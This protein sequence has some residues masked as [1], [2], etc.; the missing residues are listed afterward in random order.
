[1]KKLCI[2]IITALLIIG[3]YNV[4]KALSRGELE[5]KRIELKTKIDEAGKNIENIQVELTENLEAINALDEEIYL[6]EEQI[7]L[8]TNNLASVEKQI[9]ETKVLLQQLEAKYEYQKR[10][11]RKKIGICI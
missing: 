9:E 7:N 1:M 11:A 2:A 5:Q 4:V 8:I 6:Y 3:N 10:I